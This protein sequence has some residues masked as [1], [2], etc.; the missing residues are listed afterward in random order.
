MTFLVDQKRQQ[1]VPGS[2]FNGFQPKGVQSE[3]HVDGTLSIFLTD[4]CQQFCQVKPFALRFG[5]L[6]LLDTTSESVPC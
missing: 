5:C 3:Q 2:L 1:V 6:G 4:R